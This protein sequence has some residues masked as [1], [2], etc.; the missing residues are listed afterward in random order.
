MVSVESENCTRSP[1]CSTDVLAPPNPL[2]S[3]NFLP[4]SPLKVK[5]VTEVSSEY[6]SLLT[7][8]SAVYLLLLPEPNSQKKDFTFCG[9]KVVTAFLTSTGVITAPLVIAA[10]VAP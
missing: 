10:P 6:L 1:C 2:H 7:S 3:I 5:L 4:F 9:L 8:I